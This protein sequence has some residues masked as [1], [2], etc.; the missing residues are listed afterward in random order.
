M[1]FALAGFAAALVVAGLAF[2]IWQTWWLATLALAAG[3]SDM[4]ARP[5]TD[6]RT[7]THA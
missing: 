6:S 2:G 3:A 7:E 5:A 1:R 4:M